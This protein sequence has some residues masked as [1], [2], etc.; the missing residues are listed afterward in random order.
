MAE[1]NI[2]LP[3]YV[4]E[5]FWKEA[6]AASDPDACWI[7]SGATLD[8]Y[9][10]IV[11]RGGGKKR[12]IIRATHAS[13]I[14]DGRPRPTA[15]SGHGLH[16]QKCKST[17][18]VNPLHLR[19][20]TNAENVQDRLLFGQKCGPKSSE[21]AP[22]AKLTA[23]QAF[24]IRHDSRKPI[25]LAKIYGVDTSQIH[26]IKSGRTWKDAGGPIRV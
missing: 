23:Q 22:K 15:P 8:G 24:D 11:L 21:R 20:G 25:E 26:R 9:G 17:L 13:L 6:N 14:I 2:N 19:W 10:T 16:S 18:C 4:I 12:R 5:K 7:W 3:D 1:N